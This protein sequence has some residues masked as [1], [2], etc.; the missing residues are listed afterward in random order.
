MSLRITSLYPEYQRVVTSCEP[1]PKDRNR[2]G[3]QPSPVVGFSRV[4]VVAM[5]PGLPADIAQMSQNCREYVAA[6]NDLNARANDKNKY[7]PRFGD[8]T[9]KKEKRN[10]LKTGVYALSF[11]PPLRRV[12]SS[13]DASDEGNNIR[14]GGVLGVA[15]A[16]LP[17][18]ITEMQL[19][20]RELN[21]IRKL[22]GLEKLKGFKGLKAQRAVSFIKDTPLEFL[23]VKFKGFGNLVDKFDKT[24]AETKLGTSLME[25][26][27]IKPDKIAPIDRKNGRIIKGMQKLFLNEAEMAELAKKKFLGFSFKGN[28]LKQIVGKSFLRVNIIGLA[29]SS[30]LEVPAIMKSAKKGKTVGE[31]AKSVFKQTLKSAGNV[32]LITGGIALGAVVV[33]TGAGFAASLAGMALGSTLGLFASNALGKQIDKIG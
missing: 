28:I 11:L 12:Q 8:L 6:V 31:K 9:E 13:F 21:E 32:A 33:G 2:R 27:K 3:C 25:F 1:Y 14:V 20:L 5:P 4:A 30:F 18:D 22:K 15:A 24:F 16:N 23:A 19:A 29:L 10:L 26:C 17:S 7:K